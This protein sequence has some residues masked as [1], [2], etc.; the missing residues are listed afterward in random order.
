[1]KITDQDIKNLIIVRQ[2]SQWIKISERLPE[3]NVRVWTCSKNRR[4]GV[5]RRIND[6]C[7]QNNK[8]RTKFIKNFTHW[9]Q[10]PELP[11]VG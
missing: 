10:L 9:M 1:M 2:P 6:V 4:M 8:G 11:K 5:N 3:I 7:F